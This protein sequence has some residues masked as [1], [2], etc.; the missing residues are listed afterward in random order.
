MNTYMGSFTAA[1]VFLLLEMLYFLT[2]CILIT[3]S[4]LST[5][6]FLRTCSPIRIHSLS[7]ALENTGL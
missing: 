7:V 5:P 1:T 3:G 6:Q 2:Y 4:P